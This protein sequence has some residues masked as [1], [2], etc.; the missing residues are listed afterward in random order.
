LLVL[1]VMAHFIQP[2]NILLYHG[3]SYLNLDVSIHSP[4]ERN[5]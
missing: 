5:S 3:D 4:T 2:P 1:I